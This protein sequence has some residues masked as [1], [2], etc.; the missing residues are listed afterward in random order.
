MPEPAH[1]KRRTPAQSQGSLNVRRVLLLDKLQ[2]FRAGEKASIVAITPCE[3]RFSAIH[4][5]PSLHHRIQ[6]RGP[7]FGFW[8]Y[9]TEDDR[10]EAHHDADDLGE[11]RVGIDEAI[12]SLPDQILILA[13]LEKI[14][15]FE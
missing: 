5:E 2:E 7:E 3:H 12:H 13:T 14:S 15:Q 10:S 4:P 6:R 8:M 11:E 1:A 9:L